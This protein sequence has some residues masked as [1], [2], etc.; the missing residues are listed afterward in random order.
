[1]KAK[2][3]YSTHPLFKMEAAYADSLLKRTGKSLDEWAELVERD[4]PAT[5]KERREWLKA[6]HGLTTN[7]CW[8]VAERAEGRG[9]AEQYDPDAYVEAMFANKPALRPLY[10][11]LLKLGLALGKDV[12]ACPCQT[13]VPLYREHVFAQLK[14][15]TKTR[16][17]LGLSTSWPS[18]ARRR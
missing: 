16:L 14:P 4:G 17:D 3:V 13:I 7:Y 5:E 15:T 9:G 11:R 2:S 8:W 1:M 12:K 18:R 10:D 6:T